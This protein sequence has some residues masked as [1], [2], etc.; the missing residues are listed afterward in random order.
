MFVMTQMACVAWI[1]DRDDI[2]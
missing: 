1:S 2:S